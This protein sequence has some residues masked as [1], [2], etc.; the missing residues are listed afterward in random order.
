MVQRLSSLALIR[1]QVQTE[2]DRQL[3]HFDGLDTKAGIVLGFA[4]AIVAIS[5]RVIAIGLW[6]RGLAAA[7]A[8]LALLAFFPRN[9]P[10]LN[11][12]RLRETYLRSGEKFTELHLL[13]TQVE[14]TEEAA[15]L[16]KRKSLAL[17]AAIVALAVSVA[18]MMVD[19]TLN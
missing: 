5:E 9:Y 17:K 1:E 8:F 15:S 16:L 11:T 10:V 12:R 14:M 7:A 4:G 3:R 19:L 18:L 2:L 6:G 13:D